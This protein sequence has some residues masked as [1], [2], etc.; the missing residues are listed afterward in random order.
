MG[1]L[2]SKLFPGVQ[3]EHAEHTS[4]VVDVGALLCHMQWDESLVQPL[5]TSVHAL[6]VVSV[7]LVLAYGVDPLHVVTL[8][9][10]RSVVGVGA[11]FSHV[12]LSWHVLVF[13]QGGQVQS[14]WDVG[15]LG[16][17]QDIAQEQF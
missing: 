11:T 16:S 9:Q 5:P 4:G 12:T 2:S 10:T 17:P 1:G 14:G 7:G 13:T 3:F 8:S 6:S 15:A